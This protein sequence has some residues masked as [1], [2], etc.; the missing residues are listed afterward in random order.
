MIQ[1]DAYTLW[2]EAPSNFTT[3]DVISKLAG[4]PIV[5]GQH[6]FIT[7]STSGGSDIS[8][9]W[10]FRTGLKNEKAIVIAA[11]IGDLPAP[12]GSSDV[13]WLQLKGVNGMLADA[14]YRVYTKAGQPPSNVSIFGPYFNGHF[15]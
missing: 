14:V 8:P 7:N 4:N 10:D 15:H 6:Y 5:L 13:D 2:S 3:Q 12:T 9:V 11:L 1:D